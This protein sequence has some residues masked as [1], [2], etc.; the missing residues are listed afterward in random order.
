LSESAYVS[1]RLQDS[2]K[3]SRFIVLEYARLPFKPVKPKMSR[4]VLVGF[5]G[6]IGLGLGLVFLSE[7]L[8]KSFQTAS[9]VKE[10]LQAP[11]LGSISRILT[12][13]QRKAMPFAVL[14]E[15]LDK[16]FEKKSL[17]S[18]MRFVPPH[19]A[20]TVIAGGISPQIVI[21]HEPK[22]RVAEEFRVL[23]THLDQDIGGENRLQT[24]VVTSALRGEG[25]ST[26]TS[27][28]AVA[29][30]DSGKRT[31]LIDCDLRKGMIKEMFSLPDNTPGLSNVLSGTTDVNAVLYTSSI[32][33]LAIIAG[34]D[35]PLKPAEL[36]G[37]KKMA[38]VMNSL[39]SMFDFI[40]LDAP[41]VLNL[42][43]ACIL[44]KYGDGVM[45]IVQA[46]RTK[47]QDVLTAQATL[48]QV[49]AKIFGFTLTNVQFY[50][51]KYIYDYY[52]ES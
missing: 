8:A 11:S 5:A 2:E 17:F 7:N 14:R 52:Y 10:A 23:R 37:S 33:G 3:G 22:S 19:V 47:Q 35:K 42:P 50:M 27:N 43:D 36:L 25:K 39:R 32:P 16:Y 12:G 20:R 51:P 13:E 4:I 24:I 6:G 9:Q 48:K 44:S 30:A 45:M 21:Y 29:M 31:L 46:G 18:K 41:P 15:R 1:E 26:T 28:L 40:I 34:G 38:E 49:N